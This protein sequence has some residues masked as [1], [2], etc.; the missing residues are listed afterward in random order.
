MLGKIKRT[1]GDYFMLVMY[2][3]GWVMGVWKVISSYLPSVMVI[4]QG[5]IA[6]VVPFGVS[7]VYKWL[8]SL[9]KV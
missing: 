6:F 7:R 1:I 3:R 9:E 8:H 5:M 2:S 4:I